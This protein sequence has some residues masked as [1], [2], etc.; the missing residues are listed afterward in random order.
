MRDCT[1]MGAVFAAHFLHKRG[2]PWVWLLRTHTRALL[3]RAAAFQIRDRCNRNYPLLEACR[4][5]CEGA[6]M[7]H[8]LEE[9]LQR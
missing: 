3:G 7:S 5:R 1:L 2:L 4:Q 8:A 9:G 6:G